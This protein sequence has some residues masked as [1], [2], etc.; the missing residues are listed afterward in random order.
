MSRPCAPD[1]T[2]RVRADGY[3]VVRVDGEWV[4]EHRHVMAQLLGR[5]LTGDDEV[6]H[7]PGFALDDNRPEA[8][9][10]WTRFRAWPTGV[11]DGDADAD[12]GAVKPSQ[13]VY[14]AYLAHRRGYL[15]EWRRRKA[16]A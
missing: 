16:T 11:S 15:R 8:L 12:A 4:L 6:R 9:V 3:A 10:C 14:G 5:P 1:G 2:R 13:T 7:R